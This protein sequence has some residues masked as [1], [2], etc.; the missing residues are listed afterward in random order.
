MLIDIFQCCNELHNVA[1]YF[2]ACIVVV[3]INIL[4]NIISVNKVYN[5]YL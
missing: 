4:F 3:S 2:T 1:F 5:F